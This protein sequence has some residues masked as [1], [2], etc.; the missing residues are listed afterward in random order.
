MLY[1]KQS[2][3]RLKGN[4]GI[5]LYGIY[6]V[7]NCNS[8][9][10]NRDLKSIKVESAL[11]AVFEY[12]KAILDECLGLHWNLFCWIFWGKLPHG[13]C[14]RLKR[15]RLKENC[16]VTSLKKKR[17]E[18]NKQKDNYYCLIYFI[19]SCRSIAHI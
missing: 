7:L 11:S 18:I 9:I 4:S 15:K 12:K 2:T 1:F 8:F 14:R 3:K 17:N 5:C 13:R 19:C 10:S 6:I 16:E